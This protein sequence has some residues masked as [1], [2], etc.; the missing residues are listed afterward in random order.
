MLNSIIEVVIVEDD[1]KIAEIQRRFIEKI[2]G[3]SVT[4]IASNGK[5]A[6]ELIEVL[7]PHL[8]ILDNYFPD[9]TGIELLPLLRKFQK[10]PFIIMITASREAPVLQTAMKNQVFDY[11]IKPVVFKR[12]QTSLIRFQ[13]FHQKLLSISSNDT[14]LTQETVDTIFEKEISTTLSVLPKGIDKL[15][16]E[17]I[18]RLLRDSSSVW[19][20]EKTGEKVGVSRTTA[21]RY[22]EFLVSQN[23]IE[24]DVTYGTIGRPERIYQCK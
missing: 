3:F 12:F 11:I 24:T 2:E 9:T 7:E 23:I 22:L 6:L 19:T 8:L 4:G 14:I 1:S 18:E 21:R 15:T 5:E 10:P 13:E 20:A 17:K 16:L